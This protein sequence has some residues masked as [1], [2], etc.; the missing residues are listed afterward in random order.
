MKKIKNVADVVK[1]VGVLKPKKRILFKSDVRWR[2]SFDP[3]KDCFYWHFE[4]QH[5]SSKRGVC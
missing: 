3:E 5:R 1:L 2:I 4:S